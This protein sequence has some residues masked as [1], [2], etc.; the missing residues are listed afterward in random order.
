[1]STHI[2]KAFCLVYDTFEDMKKDTDIR[3]NMVVMTMGYESIDDDRGG[4]YKICLKDKEING[5]SLG[6]KSIYCAK[7]IQSFNVVDKIAEVKKSQHNLVNKI[8]VQK[9]SLT[10]K[11][12]RVN[13]KIENSFNDVVSRVKTTV[14]E[15]FDNQKEENVNLL[16]KSL[17]EIKSVETDAVTG[18]VV[19][20]LYVDKEKSLRIVKADNG[21][22]YI[23][24]E[25][26]VK[27]VV[28]IN[29]EITKDNEWILP[30]EFTITNFKVAKKRIGTCSFIKY[31]DGVMNITLDFNKNK[32]IVVE[33]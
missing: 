5:E 6:N 15:L 32:Q 10:K 29:I 13:D 31:S 12:E 7:M 14:N 21:K 19:N 24:N 16:K 9:T 30:T 23:I 2:R 11:I 25:G 20:E 8:N 33:Y 27:R 28:N 18:D 26:S 17:E 3:E 4:I 1:M 22:K